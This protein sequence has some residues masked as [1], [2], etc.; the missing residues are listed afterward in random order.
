MSSYHDLVIDP[1]TKAFTH[2]ARQIPF[3]IRGLDT[4]IGVR[5]AT[6]TLFGGS[7]GSGK[8][9]FVD[10]EYVLHAY[11]WV[12]AHSE[13]KLK[14]LYF[15][16][17]RRKQYKLLK[18]T[19]Y[20][21]FQDHGIVLTTDQMQAYQELPE[22][23]DK[24]DVMALT[25]HYEPYF[26]AMMDDVIIMDGPTTPKSVYYY[27]QAYAYEHGSYY[28]T[29][30]EAGPDKPTLLMLNGKVIG[31]FA[32][33]SWYTDKVG[34]K[35]I[36]LTINHKGQEMSI[37]AHESKYFPN[38]PNEFVLI[39][40][41]HMGKLLP[42][43]GQDKWSAISEMSASLG[44]LRDRFLYSPIAINQFNRSIGDIQR[45]KL[46]GDDLLPQLEDF[47]G[48]AVTQHDADLILALFDP[49]RYKLD[50]CQ[51]YD[52]D[53]MRSPEG[54]NRFRSVSI[55]KNT[56][57]VDQVH[58]GMNFTG[59]VGLFQGLPGYQSGE[60]ERIYQQIMQGT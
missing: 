3:S 2:G 35:K 14:V 50:R 6:Y 44:M 58:L 57:G 10:Q 32:T 28:S 19:S 13:F 21:I 39:I 5:Q 46:R 25:Q 4:L 7:T 40:L 26:D 1:V 55:L 11:D 38:D 33:G 12:K 36:A 48:Q 22:G 9:T 31:D 18:W 42:E 47:E 15:S 20:K 49:V 60:M 51:N 54:H 8:T 23:L 56:T 30:R 24:N 59:E 16:M 45:A 29:Y 37:T 17:E 52:I 41:D 43:K 27:A 34:K 53:K